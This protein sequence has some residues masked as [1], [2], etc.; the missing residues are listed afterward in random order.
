[1]LRGDLEG[2][3]FAAFWLK[4]NTVLA[5]IHVNNWDAIEPI[6]QFVTA[7]NVD[8]TLRDAGMHLDQL[9]LRGGSGS[10]NSGGGDY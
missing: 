5:G 7:Q 9:V 2:R 4:D 3:T 8:L 6:L 10:D 1:M